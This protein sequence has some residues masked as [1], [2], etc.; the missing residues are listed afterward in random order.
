MLD[1]IVSTIATVITDIGKE[2]ASYVYGIG[3]DKTSYVRSDD[4]GI[5]WSIM[6]ASEY[7]MV[8]FSYFISFDYHFLN[9]KFK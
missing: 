8:L 6:T 5:T 7:N 3:S 9:F 4:N 1:K 2:S